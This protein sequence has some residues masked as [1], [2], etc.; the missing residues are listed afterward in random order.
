MLEGG[1]HCGAVRYES[2]GRALRSVNCHCPD[3]RKVSGATYASVLVVE[4]SG[5]QVTAGEADI[6]PYH[7]SPGKSRCF[8]RRCGSH[9]FARMDSRPEI[10]LIRAGSLDG[11]PGMRPQVHIW[12]KAK[13]P[14]DEIL[15]DLPQFEEGLPS[16]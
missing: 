7:S 1:C 2:H 12:V 10:V 8:C 11:D 15:D 14:W 13:A 9:V 6:V 16:K 5:F 4:S 3:C